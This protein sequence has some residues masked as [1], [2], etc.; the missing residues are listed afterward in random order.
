MKKLLLLAIGAAAGFVV[1]HQVNKTP[2]GKAFFEDLDSRL[3]EFAHA[4]VDGYT[5][6]SAELRAAADEATSAARD[7]GN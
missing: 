3:T 7:A 6:R 5:S 1:A 2:A 4:V